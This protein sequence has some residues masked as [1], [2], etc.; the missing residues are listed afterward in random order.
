[1]PPEDILENQEN[2]LID[3]EVL[4]LDG[5][6]DMFEGMPSLQ[7]VSDDEDEGK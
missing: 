2:I 7:D 3:E 5:D 1:M 4:E 6:I